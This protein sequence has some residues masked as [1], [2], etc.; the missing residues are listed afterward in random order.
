MR[1]SFLIRIDHLEKYQKGLWKMKLKNF[2][3]GNKINLISLTLVMLVAAITTLSIHSYNYIE[4]AYKELKNNSVP[5]IIAISEA[6][7]SCRRSF[8]AVKQFISTGDSNRI[9]SYRKNCDKFRLFL[10]KYEINDSHKNNSSGIKNTI[11]SSQ[12][13]MDAYANILFTDYTKKANLLKEFDSISEK[14]GNTFHSIHNTE[15][16]LST[17]RAAQEYAIVEAKNLYAAISVLAAQDSEYNDK[18]QYNKLSQQIE[19]SKSILQKFI[20]DNPQYESSEL[21]SSVRKAL[22][23]SSNITEL[24][25]KI[26]A[27]TARLRQFEIQTINALNNATILENN[28]LS[29]RATDYDSLIAASKITLIVLAIVFIAFA[30][31]VSHYFVKKIITSISSLVESTKIMAKGDLTHRTKIINNDEI[32]LLADSF[33]TMAEELQKQ[34]AS[35]DNLNREMVERRH[36]EEMLKQANQH[37]AASNSELMSLTSKLEEANRELKD[38]VYIASH[39]LREPL[40]K[41]TSFGSIL[42]ESLED[43]LTGED[44]ENMKYMI[45]GAERMTKMIEGLLAYS[46]VGSKEVAI[47]EVDLN[48]IVEQIKQIELS[49]LLEE[50]G[51]IVEVPR[52]LPKLLANTAQ[53]RQLLQN[54]VSNGIKYHSKD[55]KPHIIICANQTDTDEIRVEVQDNGIGIDEKYFDDIFKMFRRLHSRR[56]YEGTGIGLA[57]CKKIVE[58][59]NGKIGVESKPGQGSTFWFSLPNKNKIKSEQTELVSVAQ[60]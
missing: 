24:N 18:L 54:L 45:D 26:R 42:K 30:L 5:D 59:H 33:N 16:D 8:A 15:A 36:A 47:E 3:I 32:G 2:S 31:M 27:E 55:V 58:K 25:T 60:D 11:L 40:R 43:K 35:V 48:E 17:V 46:R 34:S 41:I 7:N 53:T 56:E 52:P 4:Q 19:L 57:I 38:F 6:E 50:T 13:D 1:K 21:G 12:K 39:D 51:A 23:V 49:K 44:K 9:I 29:Q 37:L 20:N 22:E 10:E 28:E 14:L